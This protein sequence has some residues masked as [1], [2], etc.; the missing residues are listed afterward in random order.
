MGAVVETWPVSVIVERRPLNSVWQRFA[1]RPSAVLPARVQM[2]PWTLIGRAGHIEHYFAGIADLTLF[3]KETQVYKDNIE[4]P[5]PAVYVV[6]RKDDG[7]LGIDL[8]LATV[9]PAEAQA[10]AEAG[11]DILEALP[12]PPDIHAWVSAFVAGH[13]VERGVWKRRRDRVDP[14]ALAASPRRRSSGE[15]RNE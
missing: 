12:M 13:H 8:L 15:H 3:G 6:L 10:H 14:E 4:A 11:D 5:E 9:D 1:W 7:P 2:P